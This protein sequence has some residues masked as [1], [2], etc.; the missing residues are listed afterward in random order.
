MLAW[1]APAVIP[2]NPSVAATTA[3]ADRAA[4]VRRLSLLMTSSSLPH[5]A[6]PGPPVSGPWNDPRLVQEVTTAAAR[7]SSRTGL[8]SAGNGRRTPPV[9]ATFAVHRELTGYAAD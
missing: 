7:P 5:A 4:R 9:P 8:T 6:D 1:A 2:E 3:V